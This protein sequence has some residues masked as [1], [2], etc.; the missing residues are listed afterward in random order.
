[1]QSL[2][3]TLYQV[4]GTKLEDFRCQLGLSEFSSWTQTLDPLQDRRILVT[5]T[6]E[7][8]CQFRAL[9]LLYGVLGIR[10]LPQADY[11]HRAWNDCSLALNN[12][13]LK[14][15]IL[16][17]TMLC[18]YYRG[19]YKS[20]KFGFDLQ[21]VARKL[22]LTC[23]DEYLNDLSIFQHTIRY[24]QLFCFFGWNCLKPI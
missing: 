17:G 12:S 13:G 11:S 4:T 22:M 7:E 16:K 6:D 1:M 3:H 5:L 2:A 14:P 21:S 18:G 10:G 24:Y 23:S 9:N 19:P 20:G 8:K 15:A